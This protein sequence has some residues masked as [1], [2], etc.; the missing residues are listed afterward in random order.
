ME[1]RRR[2]VFRGNAAAIGGRIVRP[3]D[4]I[5]DSTVT[6]SLTVVGGRSRE[7][8]GAARFVDWVSFASACTSAEGP[9][10]DVQ[11]QIDFTNGRIPED[12][13]TS[14]THVNVDV[15]GLSIGT[16][17]PKLTVKHLH[18]SLNSKSPTGSGEP[19]IT[20]GNDTVIEGAAIDGRLLTIELALPIFQQHDTMSKL[21]VA[22]DNPQFAKDSGDLLYMT[23]ATS[24]APTTPGTV[25]PPSPPRRVQYC[26]GTMYATIVKSIKW[27]GEAVEG[28]LR[29]SVIIEPQRIFFGELLTVRRDGSPW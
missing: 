4:L 16:D 7:R 25:P 17:K 21:L 12:A 19:P 1:L 14:S 13:L 5:I 27:A 22:A 18:L 20:P 2:F 23:P 11:R 26:S 6:S 9:F 8:A 24:G 28:V 3:S 29:N 15:T 10:D